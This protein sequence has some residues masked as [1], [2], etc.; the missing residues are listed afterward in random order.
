MRPC[1]RG[2]WRTLINA[3]SAQSRELPRKRLPSSSGRRASRA[4]GTVGGRSVGRLAR[5]EELRS[6]HPADDYT[7]THCVLC[8]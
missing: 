1:R 8:M 3:S 5:Q 7:C 2:L 6:Q 4:R